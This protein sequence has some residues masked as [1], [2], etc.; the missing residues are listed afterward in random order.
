M[1]AIAPVTVPDLLGHVQKMVGKLE[2]YDDDDYMP[3]WY[4]P[5]KKLAL[6]IPTANLTDFTVY[7]PVI[8][9]SDIGANCLSTGYDIRFTADDGV[10]LLP[11]ERV[12]FSVTDG[13]AS[14]I[15]WVK[16]PSILTTGTY[17]YCW[18]GN[19][20]ATD[21]ST[22]ADAWDAHHVAVY[23]MQDYDTSHIHDSTANANH[24]TKSGINVPQEVDAKIGKG[25]SF[26]ATADII[27]VAD[28]NSLDLVDGATISIWVSPGSGVVSNYAPLVTK[29]S[30]YELRL[31]YDQL[32][33]IDYLVFH[34]D[35][36]ISE[37]WSSSSIP[38]GDWSHVIMVYEKNVS[39]RLYID[40]AL[41]SSTTSNATKDIS[42]NANAMSIRSPLN[43]ISDEI[44]ISSTARS[45]AWI[46]YEY[47]NQNAVDGGITW[48]AGEFAPGWKNL[49]SINGE[50]YVIS[51]TCTPS[52]PTADGTVKIGSWSAEI[53]N[54]D[55]IFS[56]FN[57]GS[58][59]KN[60]LC[61]GRLIRISLGGI[62]GGTPY[63]WKRFV[64]Y[65]GEPSFDDLTQRIS[66]SGDDLCKPLADT[67]LSFPCNYWGKTA[68][69]D[70]VSSTG[71]TG[72]ELY[73]EG[74][75][76]DIASEGNNVAGWSDLSNA[77][78]VSYAD[79]GGGSTYVGRMIREAAPGV[80][81]VHD[82]NI[83]TVVRGEQYYVTIKHKKVSGI[84]S[85]ELRL[86][87]TVG[88]ALTLL[89]NIVLSASGWTSGS[90]RVTAL[91]SGALEGRLYWADG[92]EN[93][94]LR[95][96][97]CS[98]KLYETSWYR[99]QMPADCN[100]PYYV[101]LGAFA[102]VQDSAAA[103]VSGGTEY[104]CT[105]RYWRPAGNIGK[106]WLEAY[107]NVSGTV[108]LL[109]RCPLTSESVAYVGFLFT[110]INNTD[111]YLRLTSEDGA[112]GDV[113]YLDRISIRLAA[114]PIGS[115]LYTEADAM[116]TVSEANNVTNWS[117]LLGCTFAS[118]SNTDGG[119]LYAGK[120]VRTSSYN[121]QIVIG[122]R[123]D[124]G[125]FDGYLYDALNQYFYFDENRI[126]EN[127]TQNLNVSY[128]TD[129][130]LEN[131]V[132]D[133]LVMAGYYDDQASALADMDYTATG[134]TLERV[135]FKEGTTGVEAMRL[136][137]ERVGYRFWFDY[138]GKPCFHPN[139]S[140]SSVIAFSF[141]ESDISAKNPYQDKTVIRNSVSIEGAETKPFAVTDD[142]R[143][144]K[145]TASI[146]DQDS[147]DKY[148]L[149]ALQLQNSLFQ[150]RL[151]ISAMAST[152]LAERKDAK[153]Y[154]TLE[155]KDCPAPLEIGDT[156][157]WTRKY[158]GT[159]VTFTGLIREMTLTDTG[160][161][162]YKVEISSWV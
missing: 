118:E 144:T 160:G 114:P 156:I 9:D 34:P 25:Q 54:T 31:R 35:S 12:S 41:D 137:C 101:T 27:S 78:F 55:D 22:P 161:F 131:V 21:G 122:S 134:V 110:A 75:A 106:A 61:M 158:A 77:T 136:L 26:A 43:G 127:G 121:E 4:M 53:H 92:A 6:P 102:Y 125:K 76:M 135:W 142:Q 155:T 93:D 45:A 112:A 49:N 108:T 20:S 91:K 2:I 153:W 59:Y 107:Q 18:Y 116:D 28:S 146:L 89:G 15:F 11:Y 105:F 39:L 70:S 124:E 32:G 10:T 152:L 128:Y 88:G 149:S 68:I 3:G 96:D 109:G 38:I 123:D 72:A 36:S 113:I 86:Y 145:Y 17:I 154:A 98:V 133:L 64:G 58:A 44:R 132:A 65:L 85:P 71:V 46:A 147:I 23:H 16:V 111:I 162:S 140:V 159:N 13:K 82:A 51:M 57:S 150:D 14:G 63:Y 19:A 52:G 126:V 80:A 48:G 138:N 73:V 119:S 100:G 50:N 42:T 94:E 67:K 37:A 74:D 56:P 30:A 130:V 66:L 143:D 8:A 29:T 1:Q 84:Y 79:V 141:L 47:A 62:F 69:F 139:P 117:T 24:G 104:R 33:K 81:Y 97:Q 129:Q 90:V 95:V 148:G 40:G 157:E 103:S 120:F 87:Q 99:Y 7:V 115:E 60:L 83:A 5:P 151:S